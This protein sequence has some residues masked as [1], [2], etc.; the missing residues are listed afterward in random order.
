M[1]QVAE[2]ATI[3][4]AAEE[5]LEP[6]PGMVLRRRIFGHWGLLIGGGILAVIVAMALLAPL[7]SPH[8]PYDQQLVR[9]L[10]PPVWHESAKATWTHPL[11]TDHLGRDYMSRL[12]YGAQVSLMIGFLG[13]ALLLGA[14]SL[15]WYREGR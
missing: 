9:K 5:I 7:I 6:S 4:P 8:D 10:I 13:L 15:T 3:P 11:G 12:F 1:A 14:L 2:Y